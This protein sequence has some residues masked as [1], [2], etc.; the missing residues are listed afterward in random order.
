MA[1]QGALRP[2]VVVAGH[3]CLDVIPALSDVLDVRPGGLVEIGPPAVSTGG[4]VGNVGLA[5]YRLGVPVRL[6]GKIGDDMF[7]RALLDVLA[8]RAPRLAEGMLA[9]PS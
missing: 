3:I 5:L 6:M 7:G 9:T 8:E 4:P 1:S 2:Q